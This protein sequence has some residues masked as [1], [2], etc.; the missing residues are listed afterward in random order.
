MDN[1]RVVGLVLLAIF[2]TPLFA[3]VTQAE[4][5]EDN[6]LWNIIGPER[7]AL[8]DEFG[9]HGYEGLNVIE[10]PE[11]V[12]DCRDYLMDFT[13]AS[14]W[15]HNPISYGLPNDDLNATTSQLFVDAGFEIVGDIGQV[16]NQQLRIISRTTSLEKGQTDMNALRDAPEDSLLSLYWIAKWHDVNIREDKDAIELLES[17]EI[18]FTTWGEWHNHEKSSR[19]WEH[20]PTSSDYTDSYIINTESTQSWDVP[21][22]AWF[23]WSEPPLKITFNGEIAPLLTIEDR[24]LRIGV[25]MSDGGAWVTAS[26]G[27]LVEFE[28]DNSNHN[29]ETPDPQ[30]TFNGLHH[31]VVVVGHHVTDLHKWSSDFHESPLRFT[32]LIERPAALEVDWRLPV[33]AAVVLIATP[34]AIKYIVNKDQEI[35]GMDKS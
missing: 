16:D 5:D 32:W 25:R 34:A 4:W 28:F 23:S 12:M 20:Y 6:W 1:R 30:I 35:Q 3:P 26:S 18:W 29:L 15:G 8:G 22:T 2:A 7:L 24:H 17:Q 33:I 21:G 19:Y 10:S 14:I 31:S 9:C 11:V 27:M 13:N